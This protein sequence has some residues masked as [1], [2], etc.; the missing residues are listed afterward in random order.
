M[1]PRRLTMLVIAALAF[2][3]I[4]VIVWLLSDVNSSIYKWRF[5]KTYP[6]DWHTA[7]QSLA[8]DSN[9]F[10]PSEL[11]TFL[12]ARI[13]APNITQEELGSI[14]AF[15]M[16]FAGYRRPIALESITLEAKERLLT[17][18]F[19]QLEMMTPISGM[20][21]LALVEVIKRDQPVYKAFFISLNGKR[22]LFGARHPTA[23]TLWFENQAYPVLR[24]RY[25]AWWSPEL[26]ISE[27]LK[28]NP[29]AAS[30]YTF[31]PIE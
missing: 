15:S 17:F 5:K 23:D 8:N 31:E 10:L 20:R 29:L 22:Y 16:R 1:R 11:D 25:I 4:A 3:G 7:L 24:R 19:N 30:E 18:V 12:R 21:A 13:E 6:V 9:G 2:L 26:L 14:V 28:I 27:R